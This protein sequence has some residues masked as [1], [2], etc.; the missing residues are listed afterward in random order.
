MRLELEA[1]FDFE[2]DIKMNT[3]NAISIGKK[4]L[5]AASPESVEVLTLDGWQWVDGIIV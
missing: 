4:N 1:T 2:P 3:L 5:M